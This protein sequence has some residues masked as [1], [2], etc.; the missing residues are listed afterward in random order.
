MH[1]GNIQ[2]YS[3]PAKRF[4]LD[5]QNPRDT[6]PM[7]TAFAT[8]VDHLARLTEFGVLQVDFNDN[9][10]DVTDSSGTRRWDKLR[11][12]SLHPGILTSDVAVQQVK[13]ILAETLV[14]FAFCAGHCVSGFAVK[15]STGIDVDD[16]LVGR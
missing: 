4:L 14:I 1:L 16:S 10:F 13:I 3:L 6:R 9:L 15:L 5:H 12:Q 8:V 7:A 2:A 11:Y